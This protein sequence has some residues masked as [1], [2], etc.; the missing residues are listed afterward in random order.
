[1]KR[2]EAMPRVKILCKVKLVVFKLGGMS[3]LE[4]SY[5]QLK[6]CLYYVG[7]DLD[8]PPF[9]IVGFLRAQY[10]LELYNKFCGIK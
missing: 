6:Y 1:M 5:Q 2:R 9:F 3:S 4:P 8:I 7:S 10:L